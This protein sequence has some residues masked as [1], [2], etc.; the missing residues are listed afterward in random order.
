[1]I[2][3]FF[4]FLKV[5]LRLIILQACISNISQLVFGY[6][7]NGIGAKMRLNGIATHK[8]KEILLDEIFKNVQIPIT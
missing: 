4:T 7:L 2:F 6:V 3:L 8:K 1:M 5:Q